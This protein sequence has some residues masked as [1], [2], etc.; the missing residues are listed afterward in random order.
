[1]GFIS[2]LEPSPWSSKTVECMVQR[3]EPNPLI[4]SCPG[5]KNQE[6]NHKYSPKTLTQ[7]MRTRTRN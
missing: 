2:Y 1:M 5:M 3:L 4:A 6:V 7:R